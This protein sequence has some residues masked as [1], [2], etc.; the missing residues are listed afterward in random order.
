MN[1]EAVA[2]SP[3]LQATRFGDRAVAV[4]IAGDT[5]AGPRSW[6]YIASY[7]DTEQDNVLEQERVRQ[8]HALIASGCVVYELIA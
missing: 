8:R 3:R 4:Q 5:E 7:N 6:W 1:P 2:V